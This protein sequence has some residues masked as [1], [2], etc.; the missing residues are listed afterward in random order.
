MVCIKNNQNDAVLYQK[1]LWNSHL[2]IYPLVVLL[3]LIFVGVMS[4]LILPGVIAASVCA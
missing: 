1:V 4:V 3:L 2:N